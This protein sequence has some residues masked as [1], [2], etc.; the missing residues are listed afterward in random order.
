MVA[1]PDVPAPGATRRAPVPEGTIPVAIG[2]FIAGVASYLFLKVGKLALGSDEALQPITSLWVATFALAPGV[3]LP[4][5][6]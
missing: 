6:Q 5:E 1:P 4:I 2:L 3:F